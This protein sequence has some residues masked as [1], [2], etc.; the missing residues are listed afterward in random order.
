MTEVIKS[1]N[2][3]GYVYI[4]ID[5]KYNKIYVGHKK[6]LIED[7]PNYYGS[8]KLIR[9]IKKARGTFF[10]EKRILGICSSRKEL[11]KCETEC[12]LF[13]NALDSKYGY[14]IKLEDEG[15]WGCGFSDE[16]RKNLSIAQKGRDVWNTGLTKDTDVRML[17]L[18]ENRKGMQ[19]SEEHKT[20]LSKAAKKRTNRPKGYVGW[21]RGLTKETDDR[22]K[23][24][25]EAMKGHE[26]SDE[27]KR[28]ISEKNKGKHLTEETKQKIGAKSK[29]RI[30]TDETK[31]K[32][33][34]AHTGKKHTEE[35]KAKMRK[36][37]NHD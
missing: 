26:I 29:G 19:F 5:K 21:K 28:K 27:T 11:L 6:G 34:I 3:Y 1:E 2:Y 20:N 23:K 7:S 12:K 10:L 15:A 25:S 8:G 32:M 33:S 17:L 24:H 4:I 35:S 16:H 37:F 18:A 13:F 9:R 31:Q 22:V 30:H 36:R 14:N